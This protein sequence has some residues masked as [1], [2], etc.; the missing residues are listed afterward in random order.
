[1]DISRA[2]SIEHLK[3]AKFSE[4]GRLRREKFQ[5]PMNGNSENGRVGRLRGE[6]AK[7]IRILK[8]VGLAD[9]AEKNAKRMGME[10]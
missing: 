8:M 4:N 3:S 6:N 2:Y 5:L 9:F 1:M 10:C 7:R